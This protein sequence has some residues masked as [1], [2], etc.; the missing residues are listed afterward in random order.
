[1]GRR[2][3]RTAAVLGL[4]VIGGIVFATPAGAEVTAQSGPITLTESDGD[5]KGSVT[6]HNSE[7]SEITVTP[8]TSGTGDEKACAVSPE[9]V[10][11]AENATRTLDVTFTGCGGGDP[12]PTLFLS[13]SDDTDT[14]VLQTTVKASTKPDWG[15]LV[16]FAPAFVLAALAVTV[17]AL[18]GGKTWDDLRAPASGIEASWS[19]QDSW[20]ANINLGAGIIAGVF[21][22]SGILKNVLGTEPANE[23]AV[24]AVAAAFGVGLSAA[25]V[26]ITKAFAEKGKPIALAVVVAAIPTL[27]GAF[28]QVAVIWKQSEQLDLGVLKDAA[29]I[30]ALGAAIVLLAYG[31]FSIKHFVRDYATAA[32]EQKKP[33]EAMLA[34]ALASLSLTRDSIGTKADIEQVAERARALAAVA[35]DLPFPDVPTGGDPIAALATSFSVESEPPGVRVAAMI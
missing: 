35:S 28:G 4:A 27:T 15:S 5:L 9:A 33:S 20:V 2:L 18:T 22:A 32:V 11:V 21:A 29:P 16:W 8:S 7:D 6:V 23:L 25:G 14:K 19:F 13:F 12:A 26:L 17:G 3:A 10:E 24:M 1:M 31:F 30:V 34:G